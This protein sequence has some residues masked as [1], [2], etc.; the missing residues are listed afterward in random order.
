MSPRKIRNSRLRRCSSTAP[1][2]PVSVHPQIGDTD[3]SKLPEP[4]RTEALAW[5]SRG[6]EEAL[7]DYQAQATDRSFA[8]HC[9]VY[10]FQKENLLAGLKNALDRGVDVNI[11]EGC[12]FT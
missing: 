2:R 11:E 3:P 5:L 7:L 9:A 4:K 8:L 6:L 10:E 1:R 12:L